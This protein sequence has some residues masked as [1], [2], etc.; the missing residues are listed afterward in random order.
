MPLT[1]F[2]P[3]LFP[4][5]SSVS[6]CKVKLHSPPKQA[7]RGP[8]WR[9]S[10]TKKC[11]KADSTL[12]TSQAVPHPSTIRAL[13]CLT[14]EVRRDPVH[15]TWYGRQRRMF[16]TMGSRL[17]LGLFATSGRHRS[18]FGSRYTS[19]L[20][21]PRKPFFAH[22]HLHPRRAEVSVSLRHGEYATMR[23]KS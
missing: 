23:V 12:R 7:V 18:H 2:S 15:S 5:I 21:R 22:T 1:F 3:R 13:S 10:R 6:P 16:Q 20:L 17:W 19:G 11:E 14:S 4:F 8:H 9:N